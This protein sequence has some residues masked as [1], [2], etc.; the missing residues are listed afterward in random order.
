MEWDAFGVDPDDSREQLREAL[1]V[2]PRMWTEEAFEWQSE[3]LTIPERNVVPKP[4]QDPHPP[5][6][7]TCTSPDSF[8]M[9]GELGVGVLATTL[10]TPLKALEEMF[11]AYDNALEGC[12]PAGSFVN[13]QKAVF[14]FMHCAETRAE[15]I[16]SRAAES[17]LWFLNAAPSVFR[18]PRGVWLD[19]IRG[20][21][22]SSDPRAVRSVADNEISTDFDL[23]DPVPVIR[24]LNRQMAGEEIRAEEAFEV[25]EEIESVVIGDVESCHAK[26][27][28]Y[29]SIGIDRL[30]CLMSFGH[31]SQE[32]TLRSIRLAG[33]QLV[34]QFASSG[35]DDSPMPSNIYDLEL[36]EPVDCGPR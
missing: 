2:I 17:A 32:D 23:E 4:F 11:A 15:A 31:V 28:N 19:A 7:Q 5:L 22:A 16:A 13:R 1:Q 6:W 3:R 21:V 12:E 33:E 25:L 18:V 14:T 24:L 30:M 9:A 8:R 27:E 34:P 29:R 10:F 20:D 26:V 35:V 36:A